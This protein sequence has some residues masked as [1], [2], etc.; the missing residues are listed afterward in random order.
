MPGSAATAVDAGTVACPPPT[1]F[2]YLFPDLQNSPDDLLPNDSST[3]QTLIDLGKTM[4]EPGSIGPEP[5]DPALDSAIPS[6]YSYFGQFITHEIVLEPTKTGELGPKTVPLADSVIPTLANTRTALLDLDSIY[7]PMLDDNGKCQAVPLKGAEMEVARAGNSKVDGTDLPRE[8]KSPFTARIGDRRN[9]ANLITSQMHLAF[10][11][12]HNAIVR[13]GH[14]FPDAQQLLRQHFQWLVVSDYL[15]RVV[16]HEVL[17]SV[18]QGTINIKRLNGKPFMPV[19]FS[20]AAFRFGHSMPRSRY[21]YNASYPNVRLSDLFLPHAGGYRNVLEE[22]IIDWSNF[23][24]GGANRARRIDTRLVD[25]LSH[26]IDQNGKPIM[27]SLAGHDLL[28]GYLLRLPTGQA[29]ART[30]KVRAMSASEIESIAGEVNKKQAEILSKSG[31][32]SRTPLWF[33]IL[34]EAAHFKSGLGLGP[35]GSTIV[36]SVLIWLIRNSK[37]SILRHPDWIPTLSA[38][39]QFDLT[40]LF[41]LAGVNFS[42]NK[43]DKSN[44]NQ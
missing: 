5:A 40:D 23:I 28:R 44:G 3:A 10:L 11:R 29:V 2:D 42:S 21:D 7:G 1:H 14:S 36:A 33:Y 19:E 39:G 20:A 12:A 35:V 37:H 34:A 22:W 30:L 32:S 9:D 13:L 4:S 25:P 17:E 26:L 43:G 6:V 41:N 16:D 38:Q 8:L 18:Q 24:P 31:M 15:P 27:L